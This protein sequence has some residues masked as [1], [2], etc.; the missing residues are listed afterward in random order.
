MVDMVSRM[1]IHARNP[2][3]TKLHLNIRT[4][5]LLRHL[6]QR[7]LHRSRTTNMMDRPVEV[8]VVIVVATHVAVAR[9]TATTGVVIVN[10]AIT[11]TITTITTDK[12]VDS[13][14][15]MI[16]TTMLPR[17]RRRSVRLTPLVLHL[18]KTRSRKTMRWKRRRF[19]S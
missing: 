17:V 6:T 12:T 2:S 13:T 18:A 8:V 10:R 9:S 5:P 1:P 19:A 15:S 3:N 14:I 4:M 11:I 7:F 16:S